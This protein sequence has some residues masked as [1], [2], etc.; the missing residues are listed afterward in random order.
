M[1]RRSPPTFLTLPLELR[2]DIYTHLLILPP[3][4]PPEIQPT[5]YR[6]AYS[7]SPPSSSPGSP[8]QSTLEKPKLHP[9]ILRVNPQTH[10]EAL[11]ILYG[12]NTF[13][14]HPVLLTACP[15]LYH[16]RWRIRVRLD[17]PVAALTLPAASPPSLASSPTTSSPPTPPLPSSPS[18]S[19]S[20]PTEPNPIATAFTN[21][22]TLTLD[23]YTSTF[24]GGVGADAL[25][26]FESV[27]GVRKVRIRGMVAGFE[28]YLEWLR[29]RMTMMPG[30]GEEGGEY[31]PGDEREGRRLAGWV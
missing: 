18:S 31:V 20:Q 4:T 6:C 8:S 2:L 3:P 13:A 16:P 25:R 30:E 10:A 27:R 14:A 17:V 15:T 11:P 26:P 23:L 24:L 19:P 7:S 28:R 1:P 5:T 9:Q 29:G 21:T 22:D 12:H